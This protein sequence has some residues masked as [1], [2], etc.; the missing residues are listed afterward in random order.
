[1]TR[2]APGFYDALALFGDRGFRLDCLKWL[3]S[4]FGVIA[5]LFFNSSVEGAS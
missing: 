1:L 4:I 5:V 2:K 3:E